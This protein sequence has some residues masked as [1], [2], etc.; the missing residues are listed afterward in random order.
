[1]QGKICGFDIVT[2]DEVNGD[3]AA[4]LRG[5]ATYAIH[6]NIDNPTGTL[7]S[8][9]RT[10][11]GLESIEARLAE[12]IARDEKALAEYK[13]QIER[14]FEHEERLKQLLAEQAK[15]NAELDLDKDDAQAIVAD[16]DNEAGVVI[17]VDIDGV[18]FDE[19]P[20]DYDNDN[21]GQKTKLRQV[22]TLKP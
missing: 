7:L 10:L 22:N 8:I 21:G 11:R 19:A 18:S 20:E 9:E 1:M 5:N 14:A 15:L 17:D 3:I 13:V 4:Y 16:N 2:R 6:Y 12:E